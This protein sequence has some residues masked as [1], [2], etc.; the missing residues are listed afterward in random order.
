MG[1]GSD[2]TSERLQVCSGGVVA[3]VTP[4]D[5]ERP[6]RLGDS[7]MR[8]VWCCDAFGGLEIC[9]GGAAADVAPWDME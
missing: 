9:S 4:R 3:D 5:F 2:G 6:P 1:D 7:G 8:V